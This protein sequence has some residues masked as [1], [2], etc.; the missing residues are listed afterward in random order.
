MLAAIKPGTQSQLESGEVSVMEAWYWVLDETWCA[1]TQGKVASRTTLSSR[2]IATMRTLSIEMR[3]VS[4]GRLALENKDT[5]CSSWQTQILDE[6]DAFPL[7]WKICLYYVLCEELSIP[8]D[9]L[10]SPRLI[11]L[12]RLIL[13]LLPHSMIVTEP[14]SH[15]EQ[16]LSLTSQVWREADGTSTT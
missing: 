15:S 2:G 9:I 1:W 12:L 8:E 6:I 13:L 16:I 7:E 5:A 10:T 11:F 14:K 4:K 3:G